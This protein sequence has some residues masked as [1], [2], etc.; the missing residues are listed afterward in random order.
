VLA[1]GPRDFSPQFVMSRVRTESD[2]CAQETVALCGM[3]VATISPLFFR[4]NLN[5]EDLDESQEEKE[6][7]ILTPSAG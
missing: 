5:L 2:L 7:A 6:A 1:Q 3:R 4:N